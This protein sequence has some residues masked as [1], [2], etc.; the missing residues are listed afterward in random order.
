M[1]DSVKNIIDGIFPI[2]EKSFQV[3]KELLVLETYKKGETF[4]QHH[5]VKRWQGSIFLK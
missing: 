2:T 4:I 3:I 1:D 5:H